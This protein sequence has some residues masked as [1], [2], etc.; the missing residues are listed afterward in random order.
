[1]L[2]ILGTRLRGRIVEIGTYGL[3]RYARMSNGDTIWWGS[4]EEVPEEVARAAGDLDA[5]HQPAAA[6]TRAA[7]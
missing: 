4:E 3:A 6:A 1:M 5:A 7:A 2:G